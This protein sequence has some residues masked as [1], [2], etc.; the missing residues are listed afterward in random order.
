MAIPLKYNLRSLLVR[1]VSSLMT[2][3]G[4]ALVVMVFVVVMALVAGLD[5]AIEDAGSPD[6][7]VVLRRG[8][9]TETVSG[10]SIAQYE[11]LKYLAAIRRTPAG[12]PYASPELP[13]QALMARRDGL[14]E[15]IVLRGV[16]PVALLVHDKVH[17]VEGRMF[18]P[19]TNE[20]IVGRGLTGRYRDCGR[21]DTLHFG[22]GAWKVVGI[23]ASGGSSFESEVWGDLYQVLQ[24]TQ[25]GNYYA[26]VRIKLTPGADAAA[27]IRRIADDPQINLQAECEADYYRDQTVMARRLHALGMIVAVIMAIGAIFAAMNTMY[28]SVSA[29][30]TELGTLRALGFSGGAVML[31]LLIE[32]LILASAAGGL[33][34]I[35]ALPING[36]SATF[37]NTVTFSTMV[38]SFRVTMP[39]VIQAVV[40]A[41]VMG[42]LGG[43]LPARQ[44]MR[45]SVVD[46]LRSL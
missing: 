28:A 16:R 23:F 8:A 20:V 15:N 35:L 19:G 10:F 24:D 3:G 38:F 4:I 44:A 39:I 22:R 13:V 32:S 37:A 1:R 9:I 25:R 30:T 34:V 5:A 11:A 6:N 2:G 46:A 14:R 36:I 18:K 41:A 17:L 26:A 12:E 7:M 40:F 31:S 33:G 21:G 45:M 29:R 43:W 27:L 42:L